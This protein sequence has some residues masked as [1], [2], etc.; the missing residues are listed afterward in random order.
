[1]PDIIARV[2]PGGWLLMETFLASQRDQ[3]WG[4][5][6]DEHLLRPGELRRLVAPLVVTHG[7]EVLEPVDANRWRAVASIAA[8]RP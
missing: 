4:P 6:S 1:M 8:R 2:A 3:G 7:R 5:Q